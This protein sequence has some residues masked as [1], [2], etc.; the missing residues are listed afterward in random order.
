MIYKLRPAFGKLLMRIQALF[1]NQHPYSPNLPFIDDDMPV[2]EMPGASGSHLEPNRY[3]VAVRA[4]R[5]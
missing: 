5:P 3:V 1:S 4:S 2:Y